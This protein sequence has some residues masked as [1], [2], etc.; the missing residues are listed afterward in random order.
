MGEGGR[1]I[2]KVWEKEEGVEE[3]R[4]FNKDLYVNGCLADLKLELRALKMNSVQSA[5]Y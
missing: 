5:L 2:E 4:I 1:K 3:G